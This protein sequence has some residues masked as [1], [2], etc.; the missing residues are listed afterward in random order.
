MNEEKFELSYEEHVVACQGNK[1]CVEAEGGLRM[2]RDTRV[3]KG[4]QGTLE[5]I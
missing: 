1:A 5:G 3:I 4:S 2:Y